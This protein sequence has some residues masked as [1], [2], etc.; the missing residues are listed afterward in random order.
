MSI[1]LT[2][3]ADLPSYC[4]DGK[5]SELIKA[6]GPDYAVVRNPGYIFPPYELY[7]L[8]EKT[9]VPV[10]RLNG[11]VC[12]MDG[13][14][15]TTEPLCVHSLEF[16]IRKISGRPMGEQWTGLSP[17]QDYPHIIGNSTTKHV[18]YLIQTYEGTIVKREFLISLIEATLWTI[19]HGKDAQRKVEAREAL[20]RMGLAGMVAGEAWADLLAKKP[21]LEALNA[22]AQTVADEWMGGFTI[23][24]LTD[25]VRGA[26]EVYYARYHQ[27]LEGIMQGKGEELAKELLGGGRMIAPMPGVALFLVAIKGWLSD[28]DAAVVF[29]AVAGQEGNAPAAGL[30]EARA[31]FAAAVVRMRQAPLPIAIVTSSIRYEAEIVLGE[32]FA[33]LREEIRQWPIDSAVREGLCA[34]VASP[35][36]YYDSIITASDSSEIRLKPHRDLYSMALHRLGLAPETFDKVLGLEDSES[37]VVAIRAAGVGLCVA[38]PLA[39]TMGHKLDAAMK[40]SGRGLIELMFDDYFLLDV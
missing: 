7:P 21:P 18:E 9:P 38:V 1:P 17:E 25:M 27:I 30:E 36:V 20:N 32:L 24:T 16:M 29:D 35:A 22:F 8:A 5:A 10:D 37:G 12:D 4:H 15:T 14:T 34:R 23:D 6:L 2:P 11:I 40:I 33:V 26:I 13:T 31:K 28:E 19:I 3:P 39:Q